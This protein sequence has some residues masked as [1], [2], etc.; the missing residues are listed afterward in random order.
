MGTVAAAGWR[1]TS[2]TT[3]S[4]TV[5]GGLQALPEG[6][7]GP[8]H[9]VAAT[10]LLL[11]WPD[12]EMVLMGRGNTRHMAPSQHRRDPIESLFHA[13]LPCRQCSRGGQCQ[14][15]PVVCSAR[16]MSQRSSRV[17]RASVI[18][19][20]ACALDKVPARP[21]GYNGQPRPEGAI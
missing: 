9:A 19:L 7:H 1:S 21:R 14:E 18:G 4:G 11:G 2:A 16:Q 6:L 20:A 13:L 15:L 8:G 17:L 12:Q 3:P 5:L 10:V